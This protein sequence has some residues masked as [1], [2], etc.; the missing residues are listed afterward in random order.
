MIGEREARNRVAKRVHRIRASSESKLS[1]HYIPLFILYNQ[2]HNN[3]H[4]IDIIETIVHLNLKC[5]MLQTTNVEFILVTNCNFHLQKT[6]E[7][8]HDTLC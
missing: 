8:C 2:S 7:T 4:L 3:V 6:L 5:K 1:P